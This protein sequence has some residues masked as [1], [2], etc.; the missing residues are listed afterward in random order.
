MFLSVEFNTR[1]KMQ[2]C[3]ELLKGRKF[4]TLELQYKGEII[5]YYVN[6]LPL[7]TKGGAVCTK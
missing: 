5:G 6:Y 3:A 1:E 2:K 4:M 7:N